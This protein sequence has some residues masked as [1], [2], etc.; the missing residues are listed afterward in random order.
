MAPRTVS[1]GG[2]GAAEEFDENLEVAEEEEAVGVGGG[3]GDEGAEGAEAGPVFEHA[4]AVCGLG[5]EVDLEVFALL[6]EGEGEP[7][8]EG[9]L[10]AAFEGEG[11]VG[12]AP[13]GREAV[14]AVEAGV[15]VAQGGEVGEAAVGGGDLRERSQP[16]VSCRA[17]ARLL[18]VHPVHWSS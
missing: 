8:L 9:L 5:G 15:G 10:V 4:G 12:F 13:D 6:F 1:T 18:E 7:G 2:R 17:V 11:G 16:E 14:V 3:E